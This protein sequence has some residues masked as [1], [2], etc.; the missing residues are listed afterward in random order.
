MSGT[1]DGWQIGEGVLR[2]LR[3][4][5][6]LVAGQAVHRELRR[7]RSGLAFLYYDYNLL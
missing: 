3:A 5:T 7:D 1:R 2:G 6:F 4:A